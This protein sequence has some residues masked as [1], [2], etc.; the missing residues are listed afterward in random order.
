MDRFRIKDIPRFETLQ[1]HSL[2]Y[3]DLDPTAMEAWIWML[4]TMGDVWEAIDVH[5][6]RHNISKGRFHVLM[7][8]KRYQDRPLSPSELADKAGVTRATMT[9]LLDG[10][11][12]DG[13]LKREQREQDRRGVVVRLTEKGT[14][15]MEEMLPDHFR[16]IAKL[17]DGLSVQERK[18]FVTLLEKVQSGLPALIDEKIEEPN[19]QEKVG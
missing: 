4:K 6:G 5:F 2:Q 8:L 3:P 18:S 9:G 17:M 12:R 10:L 11:E 13:F 14:L 19:Q 1:A 16:R 15:F 7:Q